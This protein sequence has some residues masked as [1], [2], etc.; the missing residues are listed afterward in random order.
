LDKANSFN[1]FGVNVI[2]S[3]WDA[4]LHYSDGF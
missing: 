1:T 3:D 2:W 4:S